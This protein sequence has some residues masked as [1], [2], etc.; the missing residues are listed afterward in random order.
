FPGRLL[1]RAHDL[2]QREGLSTLVHR[3]SELA[4]LTLLVL[5]VVAFL[6]GAGIAMGALGD[7]SHP[8]NLFMALVALLGLHALTFLFWVASLLLPAHGTPASL[9]EFWL[10]ATR[11]LARGP[12]AALI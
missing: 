9:G 1:Y 3:W 7:G 6:T 12:H 8:V 11:K 5:V 2:G 10:W 4:R